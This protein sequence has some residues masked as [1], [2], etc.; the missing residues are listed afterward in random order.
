MKLVARKNCAFGNGTRKFGFEFGT[1]E[2]K[3]DSS[4]FEMTRELLHAKDLKL[5]SGSVK[6]SEGVN[7]REFANAFRNG[8]CTTHVSGTEQEPVRQTPV[9][10]ETILVADSKL[11]DPVKAAIA[12][13]EAEIETLGELLAFG[14][15]NSG[16][17][18]ISGIAAASE[19]Q[20]AELLLSF[21]A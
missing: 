9:N 15:D 5:K 11:T 14:E 16:F 2:V 21:Q 17:Q 18:S 10:W 12:G 13:H 7:L 6:L 4:V 20:I 1:F 8:S 3:K 19:K